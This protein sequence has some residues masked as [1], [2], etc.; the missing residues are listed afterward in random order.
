M[1][2]MS[3]LTEEYLCSMEGDLV[4]HLYPFL[5]PLDAQRILAQVFQCTITVVKYPGIRAESFTNIIL[6]FRKTLS[7]DFLPTIP[8]YSSDL[9]A[10]FN[11]GS[12]YHFNS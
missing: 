8:Q 6:I 5:P 7:L 2:A 11:F 10:E 4:L 9:L 1:A 12:K 3:W